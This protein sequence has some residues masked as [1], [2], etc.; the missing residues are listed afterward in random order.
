MTFILMEFKGKHNRK[1][2]IRQFNN[3]PYQFYEGGKWVYEM[4]GEWALQEMLKD[5]ERKGGVLVYGASENS[6]ITANNI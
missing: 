2:R 6:T 5:I 4:K 1:Y 3:G